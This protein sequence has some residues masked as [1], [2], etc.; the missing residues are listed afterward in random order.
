VPSTP[1][2]GRVE[3]VEATHHSFDEREI[4]IGGVPRDGGEHMVA[5]A[6]PAIEVVRA[7][8]GG[9]RVEPWIDEVR[10]DLESLHGEAS[11]TNGFQQPKRDGG[12]A[13][14]APR[15]GDHENTRRLH[16]LG[17]IN[18]GHT[19]P[20]HPRHPCRMPVSI[21]PDAVLSLGPS[22]GRARALGGDHGDMRPAGLRPGY[23]SVKNDGREAALVKQSQKRRLWHS[24]GESPE[25]IIDALQLCQGRSLD[26]GDLSDDGSPTG[27]Q[28]SPEFRYH[29]GLVRAEVEQAIRVGS[30]ERRISE[31][32]R[33]GL[34]PL[35][36]H[37]VGSGGGGQPS[38]SVTISSERSRPTTEPPG[39]TTRPARTESIPPPDPRSST[40]WPG[41]S[42]R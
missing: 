41:V 7:T 17:P 12:L 30:I 8:P 24:P 31:W 33:L 32:H 25:P 15:A 14:P 28:D 4:D 13:D 26:E 1:G 39:P 40:C 23:G 5:S 19:V 36:A 29:G 16:G 2:A 6:H 3:P 21:P 18:T 42:P 20:E 37:V 11:T 22:S 38:R 34:T 35:E 27:L 9:D 10:A